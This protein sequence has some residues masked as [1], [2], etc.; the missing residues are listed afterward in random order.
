MTAD[1]PASVPILAIEGLTVV[2]GTTRGD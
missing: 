1:A 2:F